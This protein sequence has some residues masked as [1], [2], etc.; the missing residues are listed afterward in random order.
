MPVDRVAGDGE[1]PAFAVELDADFFLGARGVK[2][3]ATKHLDAG[4]AGRDFRVSRD[5][6]EHFLSELTQ[7]ARGGIAAV[8][9]INPLDVFA[10]HQAHAVEPFEDHAVNGILKRG[11]RLGIGGAGRSTF[12][13]DGQLGPDCAAVRLGALRVPPT[14]PSGYNAQLGR[15]VL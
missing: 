8:V 5:L 4:A 11:P 10:E 7:T 1:V 14:Y 2:V 3:R 9:Q 13:G 15:D 12:C 6:L